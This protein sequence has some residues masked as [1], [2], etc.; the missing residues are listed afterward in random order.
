ME[1][2]IGVHI[3]E[4]NYPWFTIHD[5][6][7]TPKKG[8]R[9]FH[10]TSCEGAFSLLSNSKEYIELWPSHLLY[11][12]DSEE[13]LNGLQLIQEL[14]LD[15]K[16][17][18]KKYITEEVR[19]SLHE[20]LQQWDTILKEAYIMCFSSCGDS[21]T[22]WKYYGKDSGV[23]I[24]F[25]FNDP[26]QVFFSWVIDKDKS[27]VFTYRLN[28]YK[29][30]YSEYNKKSIIRKVIKEHI[31]NSKS[32][33]KD[34][35]LILDCIKRLIG[36]CTLFKNEKFKDEDEYRLIFRPLWK[37]DSDSKVSL[38]EQEQKQ[39]RE[40][41]H[42]RW[43]DGRIKP[44]M[45]VQLHVRDQE[46]NNVRPINSVV[47]GPGSNQELVFN[48]LRHLADRRPERLDKNTISESKLPFR[49]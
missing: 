38:E 26:N 8:T 15:S 21:L 6:K 9:F 28:P 42:Y 2:P 31:R 47:V 36:F 10:Y 16:N 4:S 1:E 45:K 44:Y 43:A 19:K 25:N 18:G 23:A 24:E 7:F 41:V 5:D 14:L 37:D 12:N 32:A 11:L 22:Q 13:Y 40:L 27:D 49:G 39:I 35:R 20:K 30:I 46:N 48:A 29:V 34:E 33:E 17:Y 3:E